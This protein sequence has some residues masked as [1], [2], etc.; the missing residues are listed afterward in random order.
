MSRGTLFLLSLDC[1]VRQELR[2]RHFRYRGFAYYDFKGILDNSMLYTL[3]DLESDD[4]IPGMA[5][6]FRTKGSRMLITGFLYLMSCAFSFFLFYAFFYAD[7]DNI[8]GL[9]PEDSELIH[10]LVWVGATA[11]GMSVIPILIV[12]FGMIRGLW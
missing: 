7:V 6:R 3:E 11:A 1:C 8:R 12:E 5:K 10:T 9:F 4:F 2:L